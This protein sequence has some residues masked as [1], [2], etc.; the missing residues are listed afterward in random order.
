MVASSSNGTG[1]IEGEVCDAW[2]RV[3]VWSQIERERWLF[4]RDV[5]EFVR[6]AACGVR[7]V[8]VAMMR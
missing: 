1:G 4:L 7:F 6:A 3:L 8:G 5:K 2:R